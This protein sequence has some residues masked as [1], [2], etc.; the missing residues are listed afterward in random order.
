MAA[1][2]AEAPVTLVRADSVRVY[3]DEP[4]DVTGDLLHDVWYSF[5]VNG[6]QRAD[7]LKRTLYVEGEEYKVCYDPRDPDN[8]SIQLAD[9]ACGKAY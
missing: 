8:S 6:E 4:G 5:P 9:I 1:R 7:S 2:T 3:D